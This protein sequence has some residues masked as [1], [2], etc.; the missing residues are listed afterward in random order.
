MSQYPTW[1]VY[2]VFDPL[3]RAA[4]TFAQQFVFILLATGY[5]GL[6]ITQNWV[7]AV[8]SAAF[9]GVVSILM[10]VLTFKVSPLRPAVDLTWRVLKTFVQSFVGTLTATS[11]LDVSH[12]DWKGALA[13]AFP[14]AA[15]A[16]LTGLAALG[17]P[18]TQ[19]ASL[20]P[21]S[22]AGAPRESPADATT[23]TP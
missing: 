21:T 6:L 9:A 1:V 19:G 22:L 3:E 5:G 13:V 20:L 4:R 8:D 16:L 23:V 10:S 7:V 17:V 14:V 18:T 15:G 12:A 11:V 2:Y